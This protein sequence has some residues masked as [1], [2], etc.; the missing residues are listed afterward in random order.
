[1]S[2]EEILENAPEE[3]R[4]KFLSN[5]YKKGSHILYAGE[6][7]DYL[8]FLIKGE[9]EV[10]TL[11][12]EGVMLSLNSYRATSFFGEYEVF[13]PNSTTHSILAKTACE[14]IRIH[15]TDLFQ[16]MKADF[17]LTLN[18]LGHF[19]SDVINSHKMNTRLAHLTTK[20]RVLISIHSHYA[21]GNLDSLSKQILVQESYA[22][23]RSVNRAIA[24]LRSEGLI[25]YKKKQ[26]TVISEHLLNN[27]IQEISDL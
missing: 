24:A 18:L 3:I 10:Y 27:A 4:A 8:F 22:P 9:A 21:I 2:L 25:D 14:V 19:A 20:E 15:K 16:W 1:M 12:Q 13:D 11:T 7:N 26:F 23:L 5:Q 17:D 6:E